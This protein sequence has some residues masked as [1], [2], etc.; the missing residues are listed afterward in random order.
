MSVFR[1]I[2]A[3]VQS[4]CTTLAPTG[5]STFARRKRP[6]VAESDE[7]GLVCISPGNEVVIEQ[8]TENI[9]VIE[10]E[11]I[12]TLVQDGNG[13]LNVQT[14]DDLLDARESIRRAFHKTSLSGVS[15]VYD[16][17]VKMQRAYDPLMFGENYDASQIYLYFKS[18][19]AREA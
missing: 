8:Y 5:F 7:L 19:E 1:D 2:L 13:I 17:E 12:V 11:V 6:H 18:T 9:E 3:A 15:S 4:G 14:T 10:Y 16:C